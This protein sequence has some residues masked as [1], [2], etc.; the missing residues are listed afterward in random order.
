MSVFFC[1]FSC[2][3]LSDDS[4]R[5][6]SNRS[7]I[8]IILKEVLFQFGENVFAVSILAECGNVRSDFVHEQFALRRLGH[9]YHLL[10]DIVSV[11]YNKKQKLDTS[12]KGK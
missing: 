4:V 3:L 2:C 11:L 5:R 10:H 9:I 1:Y 8:D 6:R 7:Q 12:L